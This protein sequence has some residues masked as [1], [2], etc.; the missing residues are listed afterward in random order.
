MAQQEIFDLIIVGAGPGGYVAAVRAAQLGLKVACVEKA[1]RLGGV[2]LNVGCI[3]SKALLDSSEYFHL[4]KDHF[5]DHGIKTGKV[6]IDL[7]A[8]MARKDQ[9]VQ[10]L[11]EN[12]RKLLEGNSIQIFHGTARLIGAD[13]VA[14][15]ENAGASKKKKQQTLEA[16][17]ILLAT[18][19]APVEVPGLAFDGKRI[20]TSTEALEFKSVPRHLGVV[21]GGYIGLELGSVWMRLGSKVT[22]VEML[23]LVAATLDGQ[24]ARTLERIL[25]KQ[26]MEIRL[27]TKVSGAKISRNRV[28]MTLEADGKEEALSCDRLLVAVGRR[29][30]TQNLGLEEIGVETDARTGQV[31][32][33]ESYRTS[34]PSVYAI[35]DLTP[36]PMLAHK[37][38]AEGIAAAECIAGLPGEVNYDAIPAVVYTWPEVASVG[39]TEEQIK[40]R[41]IPYCV[42]SYPF[43]GAGRARCMGEKDGFVKLIAHSKTDRILG[44]HIIGPRAADMIAECVLAVEFGASSED[45]ARTVHGHPTFAEA[46]QEAAMAVRKCSIYAS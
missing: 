31:L 33:D 18:G 4:A 7:S 21:G 37:A 20:V 44:V 40:E 1:A 6:S 3:P 2:C 41:K 38:S 25:R 12:V 36:G 9:V 19:S 5:A 10:E 29:P 35:G 16:K 11:T 43:S 15:S 23:P 13:R 22:V 45:I 17:S 46:L 8:M 34:I 32:V 30:L 24:V 27:N 26:G 28:R 42:G 39:L 14:V